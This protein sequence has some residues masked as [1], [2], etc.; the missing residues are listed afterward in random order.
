MRSKLQNEG[1]EASDK[2]L[3][4]QEVLNQRVINLKIGDLKEANLWQ[5]KININAQMAPSL[6]SLTPKSKMLMSR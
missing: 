5:K 6:K 2:F 1:E 3:R 4:N